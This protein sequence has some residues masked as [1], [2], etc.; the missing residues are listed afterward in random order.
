MLLKSVQIPV[1]L[2]RFNV[3]IQKLFLQRLY[4]DTVVAN[5]VVFTANGNVYLL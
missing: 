2:C 4:R 3:T 5:V 1:L